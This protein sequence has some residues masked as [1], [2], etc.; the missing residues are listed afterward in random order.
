MCADIRIIRLCRQKLRDNDDKN[1][2]VKIPE[3]NGRNIKRYFATDYFDFLTVEKK[4]LSDEFASIMGLSESG[5]FEENDNSVQ[6]YTLYF[7]DAMAAKYGRE[8]GGRGNPFEKDELN[9]L[10]IIQVHI[11]PEV[12]ARMSESDEQLWKEEIVFGNFMEDL[13]NVVDNFK[14]RN[15]CDEFI[16]RIYQ[17]LSSGDFAVVVKSRHPYTSFGISSDLRKQIAGV[18]KDNSIAADRKWALYKTYTLLTMEIRE[19]TDSDTSEKIKEEGRFVIRGCY[20]CKYWAEQGIHDI[21]ADKSLLSKPSGLRGLNGRYDFSIDLPENLFH[22]IYPEIVFY[23]GIEINY[24]RQPWE[25]MTEEKLKYLTFLLQKGYLSYVNERYLL[26]EE[27]QSGQSQDEDDSNQSQGEVN[28]GDASLQYS[29]V[30]KTVLID[31]MEENTLRQRNNAYI[32]SLLNKYAQK[33]KYLDDFKE[34][35]KNLEQYFILLKRQIM[36]CYTIND[37]SDTRIYTYGLA[38]QLEIVLDS[39]EVYRRIYMEAVQEKEKAKEQNRTLYK[40]DDEILNLLVD[41]LREAIHASDSYAEYVRS[42]NLQS[43]QT[44]NYNIESNMGMEKILIGYSECLNRFMDSYQEMEAFMQPVKQFFPIVVPD[45]NNTDV[46]VEVLFSEGK[47]LSGGREREIRRYVGSNRYL[48]RIGSP[49]LAELGDIP[50]FM[51]ML[52]HEMAHQ[53]RYEERTERNTML[54]W[55]MIKEWMAGI[56]RKLTEV[57]SR[58]IKGFD[59]E[60]EL[61][62]ILWKEMTEAGYDYFEQYFRENKKE[63]YGSLLEYFVRSFSQEMHQFMDAWSGRDVLGERVEQFLRTM[64]FSGNLCGAEKRCYLE[65][66]SETIK[67]V[68][69]VSKSAEIN[70]DYIYFE[71][72]KASF[73][74]L[75]QCICELLTEEEKKPLK[76]LQMNRQI[77]SD[78]KK[79]EDI[80][81]YSDALR[82]LEGMEHKAEVRSLWDAYDEFNLWLLE[83]ISDHQSV[84]SGCNIEYFFKDVYQRLCKSWSQI[85]Q[86]LTVDAEIRPETLERYHSWALAGRLLGIDNDMPDNWKKFKHVLRIKE[87]FSADDAGVL[88][89]VLE[90]YREITSDIFMRSIMELSS[91][92][93][94]NLITLVIPEQDFYG[95]KNLYRIVTV[96]FIMS[97]EFRTKRKADIEIYWGE[98]RTMIAD[99]TDRC[100]DFCQQKQTP[101]AIQR[102]LAQIKEDCLK[103]EDGYAMCDSLDQLLT[104]LSLWKETEKCRSEQEHIEHMKK[105]TKLLKRMVQDGAW[106]VDRLGEDAKL[107]QDYM[108]GVRVLKEAR[109]KMEKKNDPFIEKLFILCKKSKDYLEQKHYKTGK[110]KDAFLNGESIE[111][112]LRAYYSRKIKNAR[113]YNP[114]AGVSNNAD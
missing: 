49:T 91:F 98:C 111:F 43:L 62:R 57:I 28:K 31:K 36:A 85:N 93:Y 81:K 63:E 72:E 104:Q 53:F 96:I 56:A 33:E 78:W 3:M 65:L 103:C 75:W 41:Y 45:L 18:N 94:L 40:D 19:L 27:E 69:E 76:K 11:N 55:L 23:K 74:V 92:G 112:L 68:M 83:H 9:Y 71:L 100:M 87:S 13:H 38:K 109:K 6:S 42:N 51:A 20:S 44:P 86:K 101:D 67:K 15:K 84:G 66:L 48:L 79:V 35:H 105:I 113:E 59:M 70:W 8:E 80:R 90:N 77:V 95:E 88:D 54:M 64:Q 32:K 47:G 37:F 110:V 29:H 7:S 82:E 89:R 21:S 2:I 99:L 61:S 97:E 102:E 106:C 25:E 34:A 108:N 73:A 24:Q 60:Y 22:Q 58:N 17:V 1:R 14:N 10:S 26:P 5:D 46:S 50:V 39:I 52:F 12:I 16:Y 30:S 4:E 107:M 114:N